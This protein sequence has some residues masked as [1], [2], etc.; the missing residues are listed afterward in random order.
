MEHYWEPAGNAS[1]ERRLIESEMCI[2]VQGYG[3]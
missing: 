1:P 2:V 3:F